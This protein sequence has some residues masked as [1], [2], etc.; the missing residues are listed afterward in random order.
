VDSVTVTKKEKRKGSATFTGRIT[1]DYE[2]LAVRNIVA[3]PA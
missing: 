1:A 2:P 3:E